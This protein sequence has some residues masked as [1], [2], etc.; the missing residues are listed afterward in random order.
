LTPTSGRAAGSSAPSAG[1]GQAEIGEPA[2]DEAEVGGA[3]AGEATLDE[4]D[5]L[6]EVDEV[7][8]AGLPPEP[9]PATLSPVRR[10]RSRIPLIS[11]I[12]VGCV[13]ALLVAVLA[14]SKDASQIGTVATSPL[15]NKPA[16]DIGGP[17]VGGGNSALSAYK[18]KWVVV[19]FFASWCVPCQ[20]EQADLVRFQNA[21]PSGDAVIF[22]VRFDDP[23]IGAI[24]D[25][26]NKSGAKWPIVDDPDAKITYSVTG[27]PES[28]LISPGGVVLVH[29]IGPISDAKLEDVL[30]Q[31]KLVV[32]TP[33]G[34]T[35]PSTP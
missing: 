9:A 34:P 18:G 27:P 12:A 35:V 4:L 14:T 24:Q 16:P 19:N 17:L 31:A 20:Q 11:A 5:E 29:I 3:E 25:L 30:N 22:G 6:D 21:H 28:F 13:T 33:A 15:Q 7:G 1:L 23:D 2:L 32:T 10:R 26:M 8:H